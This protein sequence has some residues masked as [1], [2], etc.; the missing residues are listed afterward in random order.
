[1]L[2]QTLC[3]RC[4]APISVDVYQV[5]DVRQNPELKSALLNGQ[6]NGFAC[7]N[8]GLTGQV[9]SPI[10]YHD[11]AHELLMAYV[12]ME[13]N[14]P[15]MEQERL[16]GRLVQQVMDMT[17]AEQRR[18]YML[19]PQTIINFQTFIEKV[20]ETEGITPEMIARQR[21][22]AELI[23]TLSQADKDVAKIL[24]DE[25]KSEID[26]TF[27]GL[28]QGAMQ[29]AEQQGDNARLIRLTNLQARLYTETEIGRRI[30]K[31]QSALR[32]FE[33]EVR[34]EKQLTPEILLKHIL[35]NA[36]DD[37]IVQSL[38]MAGQAALD[39][40]FF[41]LLT[42]EI[43]KVA[44][45]KE[46]TRSQQ[47]TRVRRMLL[48]FQRALDEANK[49]LLNQAN[50]TLEKLL[51]ADDQ[52]AAIRENAE[53]IDESLLYVLTARIDQ[54]EQ[55]GRELEAAR[56]NRLYELI[57]EDAEAQ[58][59]PEVKLINDLL[60]TES[61]AEQRRLLNENRQLVTPQLAQMLTTLADRIGNDSPPEIR[62]RI[63][64]VHSMIEVR[65]ATQ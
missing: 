11:P 15:H 45:Q 64:K 3:P 46:K 62:D 38:A 54:A 30:E 65:L 5:V 31:R 2:Q 4:R 26:E 19:Q 53:E 24:L 22:Q 9:A 41:M 50:K 34:R 28:L 56:L 33:L 6:L 32:G 17:P 7:P 58:M 16:I 51:A 43:E 29:A 18:G 48:D 8:C 14:L 52:R 47:L 44:R 1:M 49:E 55:Q 20:L 63:Q 12:P 59:P 40:T 13:M 25:R 27:F 61:E 37:A 35:A 23:S 57:M 39:Y 42:E 10:L 21:K 36:D 60:S